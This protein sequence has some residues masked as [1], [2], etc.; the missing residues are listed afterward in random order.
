M[1]NWLRAGWN[2]GRIVLEAQE[3]QDYLRS[4]EVLSLAP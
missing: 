3:D 1:R 2:P 4:P